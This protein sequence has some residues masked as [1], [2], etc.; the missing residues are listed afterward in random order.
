MPE[1]TKD[2]PVAEPEPRE[3]RFVIDLPARGA[4]RGGRL[5]LA[6]EL[7]GDEPVPSAYDEKQEPA[8]AYVSRRL[9]NLGAAAVASRAGRLS[10]GVK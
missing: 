3:R 8:G 9:E 5:A 4:S 7:L 1:E 10:R 2:Q 6:K